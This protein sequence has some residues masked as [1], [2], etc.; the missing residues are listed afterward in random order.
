MLVGHQNGGGIYAFDLD[1][2]SRKVAFVGAYRIPDPRTGSAPHLGRVVGLELDRSTGM[3]FA[4]NGVK[5]ENLLSVIGLESTAWA[6]AELREMKLQSLH[7]G[8]NQRSIEGLA[9]V[10][11]EDCSNGVRSLFLTVDDGKPRSLFQYGRFTLGCD[12]LLPAQGSDQ[13]EE[14][15]EKDDRKSRPTINRLGGMRLLSAASRQTAVESSNR[16][17]GVRGPKKL[18]SN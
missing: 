15:E 18:K 9:L 2:A 12:L 1:R 10:P 17:P 8:P 14:K 3:L 7:R 11:V 4:W 16:E 6:G 5:N 13:E